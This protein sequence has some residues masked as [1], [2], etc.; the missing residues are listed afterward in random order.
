M[1]LCALLGECELG[2][3]AM[4]EAPSEYEEAARIYRGLA[5]QDPGLYTRYPAGTLNNLGFLAK[6]EGRVEESRKC[7]QEAIAWY[8]ELAKADPG[9]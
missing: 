3:E 9:K 8:R 5:Q 1:G 4:D 2:T 6:N 7:Y